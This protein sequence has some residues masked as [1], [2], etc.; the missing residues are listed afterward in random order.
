[1]IPRFHGGG[2]ELTPQSHHL[3]FTRTLWHRH[4][5][6]T[7]TSYTIQHTTTIINTSKVLNKAAKSG[8]IVWNRIK[9]LPRNG[10]Y[11]LKI[12]SPFPNDDSQI[13]FRLATQLYGPHYPNPP[14]YLTYCPKTDSFPT[15]IP[16]EDLLCALQ[17]S[18]IHYRVLAKR[19]SQNLLNILF[20]ALLH[21]QWPKQK[22]C[23]FLALIGCFKLNSTVYLSRPSGWAPVCCGVEPVENLWK[24]C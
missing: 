10:C 11:S 8:E 2:R 15:F 23:I 5:P 24:A 20:H 18:L 14:L 4:S 12:I 7:H 1:M 17:A 16:S 13:A 9:Y 22:W 21:A 3:V 19:Q 6:L